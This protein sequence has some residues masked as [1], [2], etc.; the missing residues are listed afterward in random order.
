MKRAILS[1]KQLGDVV[2]MCESL[3]AVRNILKS[4]EIKMTSKKEKSLRTGKPEYFTSLTRN[5]KSLVSQNPTRW[6]D[7]IILD[8]N[9]LSDTYAVDSINFA[10][11]NMLHQESPRTGNF[12]IRQITRWPSR[13]TIHLV[14]WSNEMSVSLDSY[15]DIRHV[16][17]DELSEADKERCRMELSE[18]KRRVHGEKFIERIKFNTPGG[19]P[20]NIFKLL[21][22]TTNSEISQLVNQFEERIH[23]PKSKSEASAPRFMSR[24]VE[25]IPGPVVH[26]DRCVKGLVINSEDE[27]NHPDIMSSIEEILFSKYNLED[28][29]CIE[30]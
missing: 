17:L 15:L 27:L 7:G 20:A 29:D 24:N 23:G 8:G 3:F 21:R 16:C 13:C 5:F 11:Y 19:S 1:G 22:H 9:K 18:G 2:Y 6:R 14:G 10:G 26:I 25:S 12:K 28:Y 30:Y 4:G